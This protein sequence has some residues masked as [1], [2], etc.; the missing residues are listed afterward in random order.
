MTVAGKVTDED[1]R[2]AFEFIERNFEEA[3]FRVLG[4]TLPKENPDWH[5]LFHHEWSADLSANYDKAQWLRREAALTQEL[6][7]A[8]ARFLRRDIEADLD[9]YE[10]MVFVNFL[11][12]N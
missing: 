6:K 2:W 5:S 9:D 11:P 8:Y 10:K 4:G 3:Y 7:A 12:C 1:R